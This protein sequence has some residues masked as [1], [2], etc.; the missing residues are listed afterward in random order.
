MYTQL[1]YEEFEKKA[2]EV[3]DVNNM[4]LDEF[5]EYLLAQG[6]TV[7]TV[8]KHLFNT[9]FYINT[10]LLNFEIL[11]VVQGCYHIDHFLGEWFI[12]KAAWSYE[13][14]V[15]SN[16]TSLKK[17]Y[18]FLLEKGTIDKKDYENLCDTIV[19][20]KDEWIDLVRRYND[21]EEDNP[22]CPFY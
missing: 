20:N 14:S 15:K 17:F 19:F 21:P 5:G 3:R 11:D 22:F 16:I 13:S 10:F 2:E 1:S 9:D 18:S 12:R 7:K 4:L 8:N 6:L